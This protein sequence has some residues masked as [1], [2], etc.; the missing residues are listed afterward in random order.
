M[1]KV[2]TPKGKFGFTIISGKGKEKKGKRN[3]WEYFRRTTSFEAL[4]ILF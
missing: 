2:T 1:Q 3:Y 4:T